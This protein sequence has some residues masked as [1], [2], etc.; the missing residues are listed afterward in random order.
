ML[1]AM[2]AYSIA[3]APDLSAMNF[4]MITMPRP[5]VGALIPSKLDHL[6]I[7]LICS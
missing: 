6:K 1:A 4:S 2:R 3:V 5:K 7:N